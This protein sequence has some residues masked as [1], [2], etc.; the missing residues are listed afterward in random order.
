MRM[1]STPRGE[2]DGSPLRQRLRH[3]LR[4][5]AAAGGVVPRAELAA[6]RRPGHPRLVGLADWRLHLPGLVRAFALTGLLA[7]AG[8]IVYQLLIQPLKAPVDDLSL[9]LRIEERHPTLTDALASTVQFLERDVAPEGES[10]S[11]R[12]EAVRRTLGKAEGL[13]F[14]RVVSTRGLRTAGAAAPSAQLVGTVA[15]FV[16]SRPCWPPP[17]SL[18]WRTPSARLDW[19]KK[20]RLELDPRRQAHRPKQGIPGAWR[21]AG[22]D[23]E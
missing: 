10:A 2:P 4:P 7:G 20:T 12:R 5:A 22:C 6:H 16:L 15:L 1:T 11:M 8:V 21:R 13:D 9:A 17:R 19:P 3:A 18:A 23:P 14:N